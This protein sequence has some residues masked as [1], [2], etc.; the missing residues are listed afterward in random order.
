MLGHKLCQHLGPSGYDIIGTVRSS[1]EEY[2]RFGEVFAGTRLIGSID[3][4]DFTA[5]IKFLKT[6]R[7][8][9]VINCVGLVKQLDEA[10]N[11]RLAV[12][13]NAYLP[14]IIEQACGSIDARLINFSTDCVFSGRKGQYTEKDVS[15]AEDIYGRTKYLGETDGVEGASV[16]FR[17]SIIGREL[18]AQTH[19]LFEWFLAQT[20]KKIRG[21][22]GAIYTGFTTREMAEIVGRVVATPE[23]LRGV[24][25]V[26]SAAINKYD[27]LCLLRKLGGYEIE[28]EPY[29][30]FQCDRSLV[31]DRFAA[32]TGYRSPAWETMLQAM[33]DDPTPYDRY[34]RGQDA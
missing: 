16:T 28:I 11:R 12:G 32:D 15:D 13:L 22:T 18:A 30:K 6:E 31:M 1:P 34:R 10:D 24:Y 19:G 21:F 3:V 26:A 29:E 9:A 5:L 7:P 27:L 4:M 20:G 25:H 14:Q 8:F 33:L 2:A 23:A 17:T